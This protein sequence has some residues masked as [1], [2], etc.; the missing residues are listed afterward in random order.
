MT[1]IR[2]IKFLIA[3]SLTTK[4]TI[5]TITTINYSIVHG[6]PLES[7]SPSLLI[8]FNPTVNKI[9]SILNYPSHRFYQTK[10]KQN[11]K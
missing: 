5:T 7:N 9:Y 1:I 6:Q 8:Q 10:S 3:G 4:T 2:I 11:I